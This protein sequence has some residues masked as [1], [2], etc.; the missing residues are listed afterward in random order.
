MTPIV[1]ARSISNKRKGRLSC[2]DFYE[3][4]KYST[5]LCARAYTELNPNQKIGVKYTCTDLFIP[6]KIV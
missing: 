1:T 4:Y 6:L 5:T 3:A 2:A